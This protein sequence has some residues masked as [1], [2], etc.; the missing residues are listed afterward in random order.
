MASILKW[1]SNAAHTVGNDIS[2]G[3]AQINPLDNGRTWQNPQGNAPQQQAKGQAPPSALQQL[4]HNGVTNVAGSTVKFVPQFAE[5]YANTFANIGNRLGG[6]HN[7]TIQ[8]NMGGTPVLN[9]ALQFSGATG[10]NK[11]LAGNVAQ[12][13]LSAA[14][15]G[16]DALASRGAAI[17]VPKVAPLI[18]K[19]LAPRVIS[20][21]TLGAGYNAASAY[22]EGANAKQIA[23]AA[24]AGAALGA[25]VPIA[26]AGI[27][28][29]TPLVAKGTSAALNKGAEAVNLKFNG[30]S[31]KQIITNPD[32][33]KALDQYQQSVYNQKQL[34]VASQ[35]RVQNALHDIKN[36]NGLDFLSGSSKARADRVAAYQ[37]QH[38][39]AL[40][41]YQQHL[42]RPRLASDQM[43]AVGKNIRQ[44]APQEQPPIASTPQ[45]VVQNKL[46]L[47]AKAGRQ[48]I[49]PEVQSQVS[50]EHT[51]RS[52]Q[53]LQDAAV[54]NANKSGLDATIQ[55]AH[56]ALAVPQGKID[57]STVALA[58]QAIER[59]DEAGRHQD[60][61]GIHDALSEHLVK[62]GQTIQAAS[63][64]YR[65]SPQGLFYK[66]MRDLKKGGTTV[67][68]E[69]ESKLRGLT[70][71]VKNAGS[72]DAKDRALAQFHKTVADHIPQGKMN[73]ILSVWKAGLLSGIKTQG[74][75]AESNAAFAAGHALSNPIA[76]GV[77]KLISLKTG[78]RTKTAFAGG[79]TGGFKKGIGTG[80]DTM[81][82]GIDMRNLEG[83]KYETHGE[84]RFNNKL[85]NT[86]IAKPTN[87]VFRGMNAADQ[88]WYYGAEANTLRD[89]VKADGLN[90]GLKGKQ[91]GEYVKQ[92]AA[93]PSVDLLNRAKLAAQKSV[94]GQDSKL[95]SSFSK[96]AQEHP[97]AQILAPFVKVPTNFLTRTIDF[98]PAGPLKEVISQVRK[99][100][101]DQRALSEAI[102][103]GITG[104]GAIVLGAH[105]AN[106][107]LLSGQY[108]TDQKEQQRWKA[109][110][111]QPNSVKVG[112]KWISLNYLGPVGMLFG[113]GKDYQNAVA[114]GDNGTAQ[115]VAGFGKNLTGQSFLTGFS[116]FANA[117]NDPQRS[118]SK[119]IN[120]QAASIVPSIVA[121]IANS[122]DH[123]QRQADTIGQSIQARLPGARNTLPVKQ[124]V[125][126]NPLTQRTDPINLLANPLR[127]SNAKGTDNPVVSEVNRLHNVDPNNAALQ[128]TPIPV[129]KSIKI[130]TQNIKLTNQQAYNLQHQVGQY[131]QQQW[132]AL[133]Q[134][135]QY[136]N[137]S[138]TEKA[139]ALNS[140]RATATEV[141]TRDFV[142]K[143]NVATYTKPASAKAVAMASGS[144]DIAGLAAKTSKKSSGVP[145]I[146]KNPHPLPKTT[147]TTYDQKTN[148]WTQT[149]SKT[150]RVV[151]IASDG[152][153]TVV[154]AGT[155]KA[156][157]SS[158]V[159]VA[160]SSGTTRTSRTRVPK[161]TTVKVPKMKAYKQTAFHTPKLKAPKLASAK[162]SRRKIPSYAMKTPKVTK[163]NQG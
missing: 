45:K 89:L 111:I 145:R 158:G 151:K 131:T 28:A 128:V 97:A 52:T 143:N 61:V 88:P 152:T 159:R 16:V 63:L 95:A 124:D 100:K 32:H 132:G 9:K 60:A 12:I 75:N 104:T 103:E 116:G 155:R 121:D 17:A 13:G 43:G 122:T 141:A 72:Q 150:G 70:N 79:Y 5:N 115:A 39:T 133:I 58:Q 10:K 67:T 14:A 44:Q 37:E 78:Q 62:Q 140:I 91:L 102:G 156:R 107:G 27:K 139:N 26:G 120:S 56:E 8:Q 21:A 20:N 109:E 68:P 11:Q 99:G 15:P 148:T 30:L 101:F 137:M 105:L 110:G 85:A 7:M 29:V 74:G 49:G 57:D 144:K 55:Q 90:K 77:D 163:R 83:S 66:G 31:P 112:N 69:L 3:V 35:Q 46:T 106:E 129:N 87:L 19:Q 153:R 146:P 136:Q 114:R 157:A 73:G 40:P 22:G 127:P 59:A 125:Y 71:D 98:T 117:I 161:V 82:S 34:P 4:T 147:S 154:N 36:T 93:N 54:G 65:L 84:L 113:A 50:G 119:F 2:R 108:P 47:G 80:A 38:A 130:G 138:D 81:K 162:I 92:T 25:A 96:F 123:M 126:G 118:A 86:I 18:V 53:A 76:A 23:A 48:N 64:L 51:V 41:A 160:R 1:A 42:M 24:G 135:P 94:L 33:L 134:T 6:G 142:T 149:S